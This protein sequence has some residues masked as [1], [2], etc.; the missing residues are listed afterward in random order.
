MHTFLVSVFVQV[1]GTGVAP[2]LGAE[3]ELTC[4][5]IGGSISNANYQWQENGIIKPNENGQILSFSSLSL[6]DAGQYTC[7]VS[8]DTLSSRNHTDIVLQSMQQHAH[9][10]FL[11]IKVLLCMFC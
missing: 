11:I 2:E 9:S 5:V 6:S 1:S 10:L 8:F 3:Y 7:I 4:R